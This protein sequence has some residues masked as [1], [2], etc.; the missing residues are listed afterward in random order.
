MS[1]QRPLSHILHEGQVGEGVLGWGEDGCC[2][3][4]T[5]ALQSFSCWDQRSLFTS[6]FL[7]YFPNLPNKQNPS[8]ATPAPRPAMAQRNLVVYSS[9]SVYRTGNYRYLPGD[10][11]RSHFEV[12]FTIILWVYDFTSSRHSQRDGLLQFSAHTKVTK[13]MS[14]E[15]TGRNQGNSCVV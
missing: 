12:R 13:G 7:F 9:L 11:Q 15:H 3:E 1:D 14:C 8:H 4:D 2:Q 6:G 10:S 5:E